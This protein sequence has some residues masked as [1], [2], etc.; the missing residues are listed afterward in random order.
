M[1]CCGKNKRTVAPTPLTRREPAVNPSVQPKSA[2]TPEA[3]IA[4]FEYTG[5]TGLTA[6]GPVTNQRYRFN[7]PGAVVAVDARDA[8]ALASVPRLKR[9]GPVV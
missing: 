4:Y 3:D 9:V 2:P 5:K 1:S 7:G 6:Y 8:T